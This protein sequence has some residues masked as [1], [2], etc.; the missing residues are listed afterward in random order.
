VDLID[1]RLD[2]AR[3]RH[4]LDCAQCQQ[5]ATALRDALSRTTESAV[6]EPS[7]LF[8][9]HFSTRVRE[10]VEESPAETIGWAGQPW[11]GWATASSCVLILVLVAALWR[12]MTPPVSSPSPRL[13]TIA[14][15]PVVAAEPAATSADD[16]DADEAWSLV[17]TVADDVSWDETLA[18]G[19]AARPGSVERAALALNAR[20][21]S[22]LARLLRDE[23]KRPGA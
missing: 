5:E 16:P 13:A 8:W 2:P 18:V 1:S 10:A 4:L 22:E 20:E 12:A 14:Q 19:L 3:E 7:P 9:D 23:M 11:M 15:N 6:P 17:R 21:R